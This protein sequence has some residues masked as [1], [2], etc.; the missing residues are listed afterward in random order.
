MASEPEVMEVVNS[1]G[2]KMYVRELT[3]EEREK[4]LAKGKHPNSLANLRPIAR[5]HGSPNPGGLPGRPP[6]S[7]VM[8]PILR[9][10]AEN[11]NEH[12]EGKGAEELGDLY[13]EAAK[14]LAQGV[15]VSKDGTTKYDVT[16]ILK[17]IEYADGKPIQQ[18]EK[19][20]TGVNITFKQTGSDKIP[21]RSE[22]IE[23]AV[24]KII[25]AKKVS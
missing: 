18:I 19:T 21:G 13:L 4:A 16:P 5:G 9:K 23:K 11:Q 22:S 7:S 24:R 3:P 2:V 12:G 10:L 25:S 1:L 8:G 14:A 17:I 20:S 15:D 6:G